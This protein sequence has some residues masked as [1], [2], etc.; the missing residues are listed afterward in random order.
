MVDSGDELEQLQ[1]QVAT[2]SIPLPL[3]TPFPPPTLSLSS[4]SLRF[5]NIF[6]TPTTFSPRHTPIL[7]PSPL[8][9]SPLSLKS[10]VMESSLSNLISL[11]LASQLRESKS[12]QVTAARVK[13]A[14]A[15]GQGSRGNGGD[16]Q[17][18]EAGEIEDTVGSMLGDES[19]SKVILCE[20][21]GLR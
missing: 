5:S 7:S 13:S 12:W 18:E 3:L 20:V 14:P 2:F 15:A 6:T 10:N 17:E 11:Q 21:G 4:S 8:S 19:A 1:Q 9:L 16:I